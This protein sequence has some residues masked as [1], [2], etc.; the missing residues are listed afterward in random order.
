MHLAPPIDYHSL[1]RHEVAVLGTQEHCGA[2]QILGH[3]CPLQGPR[4]Y[5][6]LIQPGPDFG[7][8]IHAQRQ[9]GS[10]GSSRLGEWGGN[11][12]W[13]EVSNGGTLVINL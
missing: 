8:L 2:H 3:L 7:H 4:L 12:F 5:P 13:G 6:L 1:T 10:D 9:A 11:C